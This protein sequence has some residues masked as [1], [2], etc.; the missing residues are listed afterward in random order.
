MLSVCRVKGSL[1]AGLVGDADLGTYLRLN[2]ALYLIK[3][4][5]RN[6]VNG[7]PPRT[8]VDTPHAKPHA[9]Q[10]QQAQPVPQAQSGPKP[11]VFEPSAPLASFRAEEPT[12]A[13]FDMLA[14]ERAGAKTPPPANPFTGVQYP[15]FTPF[16][17]ANQQP[18]N[19]QPLSPQFNPQPLSPQPLSP[20]FNPQP[21]SPQP[22]SPQPLSP[23][24]NP[25]PQARPISPLLQPQ[26]PQPQAQ[27][28]PVSPL[29]QGQPIPQPVPPFPAGY[30]YPSPVMAYGYPVYPGYPGYQPG[31]YQAGT[32]QHYVPQG[33]H[34]PQ[35]PQGP[36]ANPQAPQGPQAPHVS[37]QGPHP[38][39]PAAQ[40][41]Q[42]ASNPFLQYS[43]NP[44]A[45]PPPNNVYPNRP[46]YHL[47]PNQYPPNPNP[48]QYPPNSNPTIYP[49]NPATQP[50]QVQPQVAPKRDSFDP[51]L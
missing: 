42:L 41:T 32:P 18:L 20:Q 16:A 30:Q 1:Q 39:G 5:H 36:L 7:K 6:L 4:M 27:P 31:P 15:Q 22:L 37:P 26:Q 24:L 33:P 35:G 12:D 25:Q 11:P 46:Q 44:F 34:I 19:P 51:F 21:L 8:G 17:L 9:Q 43:S 2:D 28:R 40:E 38:M 3:K 47:N 23:Q 14:R 48:N 29:L 49:P 10:A 45:Y 13:L 50:G